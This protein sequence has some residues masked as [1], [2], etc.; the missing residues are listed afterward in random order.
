[1]TSDMS[2]LCPTPRLYLLTCWLV[3]PCNA[4]PLPCIALFACHRVH[5]LSDRLLSMT[6]LCIRRALTTFLSHEGTLTILLSHAGIPKGNNSV[7]AM[8]AVSIAR[9]RGLCAQHHGSSQDACVHFEKGITTS[10]KA[11]TTDDQ[12]GMQWLVHDLVANLRLALAD[13][14]DC[15]VRAPL[16]AAQ[17]SATHTG[18][19][20]FKRCS[21]T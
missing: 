7:D 1:M 11:L 3:Y 17:R 6:L 14:H 10:R 18:V 15:M 13:T 12:P 2:C 9:L 16:Q 19:H 8:V 21:V 20:A 4:V 5:Q